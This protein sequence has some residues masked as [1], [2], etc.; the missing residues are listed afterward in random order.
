MRAPFQQPRSAAVRAFIDFPDRLPGV[1]AGLT[2]PARWRAQF[3]APLLV[4]TAWHLDEV[5][6]VLQQVQ[7][8]ARAG[9]WCVGE[10][11]LGAVCRVR[12]GA[13]MVAEPRC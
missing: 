7:A 5:Q 13:A 4:L 2:T 1:D 3:A 10:L 9:H 8:Q 6:D 12:R 11:A